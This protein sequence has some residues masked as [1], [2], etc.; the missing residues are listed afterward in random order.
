MLYADKSIGQQLLTSFVRFV[1]PNKSANNN[2]LPIDFSPAL[3]ISAADCA[4]LAALPEHPHAV[5]KQRAIFCLLQ[6]CMVA[7][8]GPRHEDFGWVVS[9]FDNLPFK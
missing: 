9:C 5:W 7:F 4:S 3:K 8:L 2:Q 1:P 6:L